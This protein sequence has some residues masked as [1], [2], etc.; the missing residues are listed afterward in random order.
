MVEYA[1]RSTEYEC[2]CAQEPR[3]RG[4]VVFE[5]ENGVL[6]SAE[7]ISRKKAGA[8]LG[9]LDAEDIKIIPEW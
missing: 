9:D 3:I 1:L 8:I 6:V 2:L 7:V 4:F 5:P